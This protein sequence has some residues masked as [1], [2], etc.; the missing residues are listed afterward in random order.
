MNILFLSYLVCMQIIMWS[1]SVCLSFFSGLCNDVCSSGMEYGSTG[2]E[3]SEEVSGDEEGGCGLMTKPTLMLSSA[4]KWK[5]GS[6]TSP[7]PKT[8]DG[9]SNCSSS[10]EEEEMEAIEV[11]VHPSMELYFH[12]FW[13]I[14]TP[15]PCILPPPPTTIQDQQLFVVVVCCKCVDHWIIIV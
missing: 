15:D 6:G 10:E 12:S 4:F 9:H 2:G 7:S 13:Y 14:T 1:V 11:R 3:D 8:A 5:A